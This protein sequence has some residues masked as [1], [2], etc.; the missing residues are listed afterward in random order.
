[1]IRNK[2][3]PNTKKGLNIKVKHPDFGYVEFNFLSLRQYDI[4]KQFKQNG[5]RRST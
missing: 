5:E 2:K 3:Q 1:M 4:L